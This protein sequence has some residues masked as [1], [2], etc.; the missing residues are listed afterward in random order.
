MF[1]FCIES[2]FFPVLNYSAGEKGLLVSLDSL[3]F[4]KGI[5]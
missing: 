5:S 2:P 4:F 1:I 3:Y